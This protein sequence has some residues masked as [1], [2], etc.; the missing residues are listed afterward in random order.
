MFGRKKKALPAGT[1]LMHYEGLPGF[2]QDMPCFMEQTAEA[3]IFRQVD[4]PT[5]TLPLEK[6]TGVE[7]LAEY[8]FAAKYRGN[9][10]ITSKTNAVKWY[11]VLT[12]S[13]D[14]RL[15][16]WTLGVKEINALRDLQKQV[17]N[18]VQDFTL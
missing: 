16:F 15:V 3:L 1:R 5:G 11:A 7:V 8:Q 2:N 13:E 10:I 14:K 9:D 17:R 18:S 6:L 4:G 12:Y